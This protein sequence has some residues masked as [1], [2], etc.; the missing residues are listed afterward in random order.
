M[1]KTLAL[2]LA[3]TL[4]ATTLT[5]CFG[6]NRLMSDTDPGESQTPSSQGSSDAELAG[7]YILVSWEDEDGDYLEFLVSDGVRAGDLFIELR[8]DGTYIWDMSAADEFVDKGTFEVTGNNDLILNYGSGEDWLIIDG[9]RIYYY[10]QSDTLIFER[11]GADGPA[12]SAGV[13]NDT[14]EIVEFERRLQ[15]LAPPLKGSGAE[16]LLQ[17]FRITN[18][19]LGLHEDVAKNSESWAVQSD[20]FGLSPYVAVYV[21]EITLFGKPTDARINIEDEKWQFVDGTRLEHETIYDVSY[22]DKNVSPA[23]VVAMVIDVADLLDK[24]PF[25]TAS[26]PASNSEKIGFNEREINDAIVRMKDVGEF[27]S[28]YMHFIFSNI[29]IDGG[30]SGF[31]VQLGYSPERDGFQVMYN[32]KMTSLKG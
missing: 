17:L 13:F 4:A 12:P 31:S 16:E 19:I 26:I 5:G 18:N 10:S 15:E 29:D 25:T 14:D 22:T 24:E 7:K 23:D 9:D 28:S 2:I 27:D 3:L 30:W 32:I 11:A 1:K 8:A 21:K 20:S 6:L